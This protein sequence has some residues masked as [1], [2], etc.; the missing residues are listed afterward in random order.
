MLLW[1]LGKSSGKGEFMEVIN[2]DWYS[3]IINEGPTEKSY[4]LLTLVCCLEKL[5]C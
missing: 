1:T 3:S 2:L 5:I 4:V